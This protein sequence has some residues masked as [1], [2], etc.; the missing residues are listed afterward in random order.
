MSHLRRNL[1]TLV[2]I[3][4]CLTLSILAFGCSTPTLDQARVAYYNNQPQ[5]GLD[6]LNKADIPERDKILFLM[7]RGSLYQLQKNYHDGIR[8]LNDAD[9]LFGQTDT[10]SVTRG[11]SSIVANDNALNFYGYPFERTYL[12][13]INALNYIAAADWQG[14]GVEGRRIIKNLKPENIGDFPEDAFSRYLAGLCME[15][16]DD[17]SN[18]RVEY[19]KASQ[20]SKTADISDSGFLVADGQ[21]DPKKTSTQPP[22]PQ[23]DQTYLV[24]MVLIG[25]IADYSKSLPSKSKTTP[26]IKISGNGKKLGDAVTI[27]D[28]SGLAHDSESQWAAIHA[29]KTAARIAGKIVISDSVS[30]QNGLVGALLYITL[31]MLEQPDFRH[32]ETLPRYINLARVP[33]PADLKTIDLTIGTKKITIKRPIQKQGK[34]FITFERVL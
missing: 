16:V 10:L 26:I 33:C 2:R 4:A 19:R 15:L 25:R 7:E 21:I 9:I 11:A 31:M 17:P 6:T 23:K 12:H 8:D 3:E 18:A 32:W 5:L 14:A 20:I 34:L 1:T 28:L 30:E 22:A 27:V 24:C 29:A 13:V